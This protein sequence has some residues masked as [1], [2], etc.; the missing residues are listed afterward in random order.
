LRNE[1]RKASEQT[2]PSNEDDELTA[3]I[4]ELF[5]S[6][7]DF[8]DHETPARAGAA[9]QEPATTAPVQ[10]RASAEGAYAPEHYVFEEEYYDDAATPAYADAPEEPAVYPSSRLLAVRDRRGPMVAALIGCVVIA[11]AAGAFAYSHHAAKD[12]GP[13]LLKADA[14]PV[15]MKPKHPG[16]T[17][18]PNQDNQVYKRVADGDI[19]Q[20]VQQQKLVSSEE[21]PVDLAAQANAA[22]NAASSLP[23]VD[24]P[25]IP[26]ASS[27][28]I[29]A[30]AK[31]DAGQPQKNQDRV[32]PSHAAG[33][34]IS[35]A[36]DVIAVEPRKVRTMIVKPDGTM[37]P[38]PLPAATPAA[39]PR[40][41]ATAALEEPAVKAPAGAKPA[42]ASENF[43][44]PASRAGVEKG[45]VVTPQHVDIAPS[46]PAVQP[47]S[48]KQPAGTELKKNEKVASLEAAPV[49][50]AAAA[51]WAMQ[52]ASQPTAQAAQT[53]YQHLAHRFGSVLG[54]HGVDIVKAEIA[55]KGTYYRVRVPASTR[56]E[57]IALCTK[58][59]A[60]GG[61]CFVSK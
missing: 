44:K 33:A 41:V 61:N 7:F 31:G 55:G 57:A 54:G 36:D 45:S 10:N 1:G 39:A 51:G 11:G 35:R 12:S 23:G 28:E 34:D 38:T 4:E 52:I 43:Q 25:K 9:A 50:P 27:Q 56:D 22:S 18:V 6:E 2:T 29:T 20:P 21:K 19:A 48:I 58:Y 49:R 15:K 17:K 37:V 8:S 5:S 26:Q 47:V 32:P 60:A 46:R 14:Q 30:L 16:G 40:S 13:V 3:R 59:K 42:A 24:M 53:S